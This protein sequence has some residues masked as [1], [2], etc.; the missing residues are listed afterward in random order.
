MFQCLQFVNC[1]NVE[2][3]WARKNIYKYPCSTEDVHISKSDLHLYMIM[4]EV[5]GDSEL[6][7]LPFTILNI[8]M[9]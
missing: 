2:L 9:R 7:L 8:K 4:L 6:E 3:F 1:S 5:E